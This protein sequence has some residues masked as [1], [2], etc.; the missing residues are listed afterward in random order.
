MTLIISFAVAYDIFLNDFSVFSLKA[1]Y[2]KPSY[3]YSSGYNWVAGMFGGEVGGEYKGFWGNLRFFSSGN[4]DL[5]ND[6]GEVIG[7]FSSNFVRFSA[8][9]IFDFK[10]YR[11]VSGVG[12]GYIGLAP[13]E[14]GL[15]INIYI[16]ASRYWELKAFKNE[17][18][19]IVDNL[20]YEVFPIG[21]LRDVLPFRL[22]LGDRIYNDRFYGFLEING[23]SSSGFSF[24]LGGQLG[25]NILNLGFAY[26]SRY[27]WLN[28]GYGLDFLSGL[29][30]FGGL[31]Y[32][33]ITFDYSYTFLG[34][35][36][37]KNT[38][39]IGYLFK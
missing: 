38:L 30:L 13:N 7:K 12:L 23:Y 6:Q 31:E 34:L 32:K 4:M 20:G 22:S 5:T 15:G 10:Q 1:E 9:K 21:V 18:Y 33:S 16:L 11:I 35:F 19:A 36:G 27:R 3:A 14:T 24:K 8:G 26:D 28:G 25:I 29:S 17:V 2:Y 37:S 39:Q